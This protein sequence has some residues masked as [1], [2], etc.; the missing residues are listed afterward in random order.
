MVVLVGGGGVLG[1]GE[2]V[3]R[4]AEGPQQAGVRGLRGVGHCYAG[5]LAVGVQVSACGWVSVCIW[6]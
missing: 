1:S 3:L 2:I 5:A 6:G 4:V